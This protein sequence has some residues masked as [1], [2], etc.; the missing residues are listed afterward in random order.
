EHIAR[1][2]RSGQS[3]QGIDLF[4]RLT[5]GRDEVWQAKRYESITAN[6]IIK[7]VDAFR[8]GNW[9]NKCERLVLTLQASLSDR[10]VQDAIEREAAALK[11]A[12]VTLVP[13]GGEELGE[14]LRGHPE[15]L[16][17]FF[18][19]GWVEA[20]LGPEAVTQLGTRLDGAEFAR[21][22]RQLRGFYDAH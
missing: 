13:H 6:E 15:L 5:N 16:D 3:Q 10:N 7:I 19:R 1:Y 4:A 22:R 8:S 18:G 12:G 9:V 2:G 20:F 14:I 11:E 21:V 17:D